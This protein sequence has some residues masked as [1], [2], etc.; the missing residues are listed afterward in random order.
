MTKD[1]AGAEIE[2]K[3]VSSMDFVGGSMLT[4]I[5]IEIIGDDLDELDSISKQVAEIV[6]SVPGT[7]EVKTSLGEGKPELVIKIDRDKATLYG[8]SSAQIAQTVNS[9]VSGSVA[10]RYKID[11]E[12]IDV[13][14][15]TDE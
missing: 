5:S 13:V 1:M 11:G 10:T 6:K 2:V 12:E 15:K 14:I 9:A 8:L 3:A 4:S 7:R